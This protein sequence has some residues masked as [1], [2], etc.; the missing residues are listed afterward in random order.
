[1]KY[2]NLKVG[3]CLIFFAIDR[4]PWLKVCFCSL[5]GWLPT[6]LGHG[7][8]WFLR[9][10]LRFGFRWLTGWRA[11]RWCIFWQAINRLQFIVYYRLYNTGWKNNSAKKNGRELTRTNVG[12]HDRHQLQQCPWFGRLNSI[13][14]AL[15]VSTIW[16]WLICAWAVVGL[17]LGFC[18]FHA[19]VALFGAFSRSK[20]GERSRMLHQGCLLEAL[21]NSCH[22]VSIATVLIYF[23]VCQ[24]LCLTNQAFVRCDEWYFVAGVRTFSQNVE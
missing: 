20:L 11:A 13:C 17:K 5:T 6:V 21:M 2:L 18:E 23:I 14:C 19:A 16:L 3:P 8:R 15:T 4:R 12:F 9:E 24:V 1:M 7:H 10:W 22:I